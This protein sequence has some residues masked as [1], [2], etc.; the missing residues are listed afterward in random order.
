MTR[1]RKGDLSAKAAIMGMLVERPDT[2][3]GV[4][5]RLGKE[6]S[7]AR[8]S[9]SI[10]YGAIDSLADDGYV[11]IAAEGAERS[12]HLYEP[13][14]EGEGWFRRWVGEF[15]TPVLR[16]T[17][18]AKLQNVDD[19]NELLEL[20]A[21]I[22]EQEEVAFQSSETATIGLNTARRRGEFGSPRGKGLEGR[23]RYALMSDEVLWWRNWG[24]RLKR[25]RENLEGPQEQLEGAG[26]GGGDS[27]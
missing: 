16:D 27:G 4:K 15:S 18:R 8:W 2:I 21:A 22:R 13:T 9:P 26:N 5:T 19:E 11:R 14:P 23:V 25:L 7:G 17:L 20:I 3:N 24:E 12:L 6:F 1:V 10:A